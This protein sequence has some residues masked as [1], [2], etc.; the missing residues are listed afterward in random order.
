MELEVYHESPIPNVQ[1]VLTRLKPWESLM[2]SQKNL[3]ASNQMVNS[4]ERMNEAVQ[5]DRS[6]QIKKLDSQIVFLMTESD[7]S[8]RVTF[9][10]EGEAPIAENMWRVSRIITY[11]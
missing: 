11:S 3:F 4:I 7:R 8:L 1:D 2:Q 6:D 5:P 9:G 10:Q